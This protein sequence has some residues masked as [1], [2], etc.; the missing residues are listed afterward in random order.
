M[1]ACQ[2]DEVE[3]ARTF[4]IIGGNESSEQLFRRLVTWCRMEDPYALLLQSFDPSK[5]NGFSIAISPGGQIYYKR[6]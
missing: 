1:F 6:E 4:L 5:G 2:E 3:L